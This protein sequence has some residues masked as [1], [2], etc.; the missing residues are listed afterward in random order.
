MKKMTTG[1]FLVFYWLAEAY[2]SVDLRA[3]AKAVVRTANV[4]YRTKKEY[5]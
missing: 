3:T 5:E 1:K 2:K 4:R